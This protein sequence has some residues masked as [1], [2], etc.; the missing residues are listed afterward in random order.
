MTK[1]HT[2]PI[3]LLDEGHTLCV[4]RKYKYSRDAFK[5]CVTSRPFD[6]LSLPSSR[7]LAQCD[8]G[9]FR[10]MSNKYK[11]QLIEE[12]DDIYNRWV[13]GIIS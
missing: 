5:K 2:A 10:L 1:P 12:A 3:K 8:P 6:F 9:L 13:L 4:L 7:H 11:Y